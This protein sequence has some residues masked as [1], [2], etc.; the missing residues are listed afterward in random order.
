MALKWPWQRGSANTKCQ[1]IAR[2]F[3]TRAV[4]FRPWLPGRGVWLCVFL[5][6]WLSWPEPCR[7]AFYSRFYCRS[8]GQAPCLRCQHLQKGSQSKNNHRVRIHFYFIFAT[9]G[10]ATGLLSTQ[11]FLRRVCMFSL[12]LWVF[13]LSTRASKHMQI[14]QTGT[15][16]PG[17]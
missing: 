4:S 17:L 8:L 12:C 6:E 15:F 11:A 10:A 2:L 13:S 5:Q 16:C 3:L 14:R 9:A 7:C 1:C